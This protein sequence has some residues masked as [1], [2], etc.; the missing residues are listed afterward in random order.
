MSAELRD[1]IT[2]VLARIWTYSLFD[3]ERD[4]A[5]ILAAIQDADLFW[6]RVEDAVETAVWG[7]ERQDGD[8]SC[9]CGAVNNMDGDVLPSHRVGAV[10]EAI[11]KA[12]F[13]EPS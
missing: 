5:L 8:G 6:D 2:P 3:P 11:Q 7:H 12:F 4:T 10:T 13:G 1:A 9:R